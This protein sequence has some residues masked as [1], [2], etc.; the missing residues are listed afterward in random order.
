MEPNEKR[1]SS[2]GMRLRCASAQFGWCR[3][4]R[5]S[6]PRSGRRSA[7][8]RQDRLHGGDAAQVGAASRARRGSAAWPDDGGVRADQ[9]AGARGPRAAA[10]QRDSAEGV[11]VFCEGG[12]RPPIEAMIAFI[13]DHR[14]VYGVEPICRVLPIA[15]STYHDHAARRRNPA[16]PAARAGGTRS[17]DR[18][19][20]GLGGEL[21]GLRR[22]QGLA[23]AA[24]EKG[25]GPRAARSRG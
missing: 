20:A 9:G 17:A 24:R 22:A 13:D 3:S 5:A 19:P 7:R 16:T 4:T 6:M 14:K 15:P 10:G 1:K 18:D 11:G 12:A 21:P 8:S 25:S 2:V 23:A